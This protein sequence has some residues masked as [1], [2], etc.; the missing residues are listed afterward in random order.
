M[1]KMKKSKRTKSSRIPKDWKPME[2]E[3]IGKHET[4]PWK[5]ED[6]VICDRIRITKHFIKSKKISIGV[7]EVVGG[8]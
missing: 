4:A 6:E 2:S 8:N 7:E 1:M 5:T 3:F